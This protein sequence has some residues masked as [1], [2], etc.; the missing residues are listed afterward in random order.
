MSISYL[1]QDENWDAIFKKDWINWKILILPPQKA[2]S[3]CFQIKLEV[4]YF[5]QISGAKCTQ[6]LAKIT[7]L[8]FFVAKSWESNKI[9][10]K[11][12]KKCFF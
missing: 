11:F 7:I 3:H 8:I 12:S 2:Q 9:D 6:K 5:N 10:A 4:V 1:T